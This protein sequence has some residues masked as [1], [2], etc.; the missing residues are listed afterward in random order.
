MLSSIHI[1]QLCVPAILPRCGSLVR[2]IRVRTAATQRDVL[3]PT[4]VALITRKYSE[5]KTR[6]DDISKVV[7]VTGLQSKIDSLEASAARECLWDDPKQAQQML[8]SLSSLKEERSSFQ[9]LVDALE[10]LEVAIDL[11]EMDAA[12]DDDSTDARAGTESLQEA[13]NIANA[14]EK[15]VHEREVRCLLSGPFAM[16]GAVLTIQAGA[17]GTDAQ[18][19]AEML[20]RMYTRWAQA[21]GYLTKV[22][23]RQQGDEAGI[24]SV[25]IE[26]S[27]QYAYGLLSQEKGTHRLV[28][29]SPFNAKAA[30]QTSFAAVEVMPADLSEEVDVEIPDA[31]LE[32]STMRSGGAGGQN[33]NKVETAV[34]IKHLPTGL[35]VKCTEER[36]QAQNKAR[37][38]SLLKARLD[39]IARE[40]Q[41][42]EIAQIR[43]DIVKAEWGQQV[44]NYVMHPYKMVKDVRSGWETSNVSAVLDGALDE[45]IVATLKWRESRH[46]D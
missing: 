43:G 42:E 8:L 3:A 45:M 39:V 38:M 23:N 2:A 29:Q 6:I 36:S 4:S 26:I 33:V 19:W 10:D 11:V 17:G 12:E 21:K 25:E 18:D 40:Q 15:S 1:A 13:S 30:R 14:L 22:R 7:N 35:T 5:L 41:L 27:G 28:R 46:S 31:D 16:N 44:R 20:F 32:I 24:K 37:A 34:R 9:R